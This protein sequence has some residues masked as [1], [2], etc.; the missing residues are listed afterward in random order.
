MTQLTSPF[1]EGKYGWSLGESNWN[2][3]MDENLLKFSYMFDRNIDG[4]VG[5]LPAAANGAAYFL[6]TDKRLY[7]GAGGI[8]YSSPT[9]EW[10][11]VTLRSTGAAYQF[12]GTTLVLLPSVTS[13]DARLD[14]VEL[15]VSMLGSAAFEDATFFAT[16]AEFDVLESSTIARID[17]VSQYG[18]IEGD[19]GNAAKIQNAF[20]TAPIGST[21]VFPSSWVIATTVPLVMSRLMNLELGRCRIRGDFLVGDTSSDVLRVAITDSGAFVND[22]RSMVIR[23]GAIFNNGGGNCAINVNPAGYVGLLPHFELLICEGNHAGQVRCIRIGAAN[24]AGDTNFCT[25]RDN[26]LGCIATGADSVVDLD[27]C[28]D[29]HRI[30]FNLIYGNGT[31]VRVNLVL[32]AYQTMIQG[33][34]I[35]TRD[36]AL[37]VT[38]GARVMFLYNQCEQPLS[39]NTLVPKATVLIQGLSYLSHGCVIE[40]NNFGGG[41]NVDFNIVLYNAQGT[42]IDKNYFYPAAVNDVLFGNGG[43]G[44]IAKYNTVGGNNWA[45]GVRALLAAPTDINRRLSVATQTDTHGNRGVWRDDVS[46]NAGWT[47]SGFEFMMDSN[48]VLHFEGALDSG[49]VT[50]G[51]IMATLPPGY[52][53]KTNCFLPFVTEAGSFGSVTITTSGTVTAGVIPA[54]P[55][56]R[57]ELGHASYNVVFPAA[58]DPGA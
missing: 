45:R 15:T 39:G 19:S 8:W 12:N 38:N 5:V 44:L 47:K 42:S 18:L 23:G 57:V 37:V 9:P 41:A 34:G 48:S 56:N 43:V 17:L 30:L 13:L 50:A 27:A 4:I 16:K 53:P 3:G 46:L 28:A 21:L 35:V 52:A 24:L 54:S 29:G 22:T 26:N 6:T 58:Y 40:G 31:G 33:N 2:L 10:C 36:G 32:G 20:D 55:D 14:A 51:T 1:L 25:V 7:F 11:V 49:T